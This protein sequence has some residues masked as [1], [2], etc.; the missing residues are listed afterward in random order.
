MSRPIKSGLLALLIAVIIHAD[1][2]VARPTHHRLSLGLSYHW[3]FAA[4]AFFLVS[5]IIARVWP[6]KPWRAA[7]GIAALGIALGQ[8]VEPVLEYATNSGG[9]GYATE[10]SRWAAFF[11][12]IAA[13]IPA[14]VIGVVAARSKRSTIAR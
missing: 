9:L 10:P 1:F 3:V 6:E 5:W 11:A 13:G 7:A 12:C 8:G 4:I 14:L 2:H